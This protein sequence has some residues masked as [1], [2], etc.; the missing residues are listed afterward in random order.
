MKFVR[1]VLDKFGIVS[2]YSSTID[3]KLLCFQRFIRLF[4]YGGSTLILVAYL[5]ALGI[6]D[7]KI[8]LFMTLTLVGDVAISFF[9]ILV[10]DSLGRKT[11]LALGATLMAG[12]GVVFGL[13]ETT[14]YC[15]RQPSLGSLAPGKENP[16]ALAL[17][18]RPNEISAVEMK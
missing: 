3:T 7:T 2:L 13:S 1:R 17:Q 11:T 4:A 9:L 8:G 5:A 6:P 10:A 18:T 16:L 12:S 15:S 14:G